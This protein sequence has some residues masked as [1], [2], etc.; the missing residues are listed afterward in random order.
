MDNEKN[1]MDNEIWK[2]YKETNS[3]RWG[4]RVYEVSNLGRVKLNGEIVEP[5]MHKGYYKIGCFGVHKAVAKLFVPN[6][7][8]KPCVD[9]I[10]RN[11]LNNRAD[12]LHWVTPKENSNNPLT[13][14]H[15]KELASK[16]P[17]SYYDKFHKAAWKPR[18]EETRAKISTSCKERWK[19]K[20]GGN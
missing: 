2:V 12:N 15:F 4:H 3:N 16:R 7:D 13:I 8:N 5:A 1:Y 20:K 6:P 19:K 9:H 14:I 11:K 18:S 10:D 17:K